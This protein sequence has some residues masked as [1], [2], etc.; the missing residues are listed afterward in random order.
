M[1]PAKEGL[2]KARRL[3]KGR[4]FARVFAAPRK[5]I[6][7]YWVVLAHENGLKEARLGLAISRRCSSRAVVRN[8]LKR[9]WREGFRRHAQLLP[10][11]DLVVL[12]R[13]PAAAA[14]NRILLASI[15]R[16]IRRLATSPCAPSSSPSSASTG[17]S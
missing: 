15:E 3:L 8:R 13:H 10:P 1:A 2:P 16:L 14:T 11:L 9:L 4:E 17:S 6:D 12:C 7:R 5:Q